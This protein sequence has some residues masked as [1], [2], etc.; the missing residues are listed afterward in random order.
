MFLHTKSIILD[1]HNLSK[2]MDIS[3]LK[4]F[5]IAVGNKLPIRDFLSKHAV[6][7]KDRIILRHISVSILLL[8]LSLILIYSAQNYTDGFTGNI[9]P[10]IL[11]DRLPVI[12]VSYIFFQGAFIFVLILAGILIYEPKYIPFTFEASALFF[13]VRSF[14]MVMTHLSAPSIEYYKYI[15]HEHHTREV[16]FTLSSGNDLFFSGHTGYPFLLALI[17]WREKRL[18]VFFLICSLIGAI[19]VILWHVHYSIDVFSAFFIT[20]SILR[21][22]E[23][24]FQK[25]YLMTKED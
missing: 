5:C 16:L 14:F 19:A 17:F 20:Y 10:D 13:F 4:W 23:T 8:I 7:W 2:K 24:F 1:Y 22:A 15:E 6:F 11:L 25:E 12:D 9:V 3:R 21:V 18:R